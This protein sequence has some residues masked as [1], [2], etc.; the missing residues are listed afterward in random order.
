V[1]R[2]SCR[3]EVMRFK[4]LENGLTRSLIGEVPLG[5]DLQFR[6]QQTRHGNG[7]TDLKENCK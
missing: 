3:A 4:H 7:L 2:S 1:R 5:S 6:Y